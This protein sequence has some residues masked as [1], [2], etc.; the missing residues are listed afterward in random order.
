MMP[1]KPGYPLEKACMDMIGPLPLTPRNNRYILTMIDSYSKW[2]EAIPSTSQSAVVTVRLIVNHWIAQHGAPTVLHS[3]LGSNFC[4][5]VVR[6]IMKIF[7]IA[8]PNTTAFHSQCNG[9]VERFNRTLVDLIATGV[10]HA[11][12][13]WDL[14][15]GLVL[16]SHRTTIATHGYT[17]YFIL[18]GFDMRLPVDLQYVLP[19]PYPEGSV[20]DVARAY[21]AGINSAINTLAIISTLRIARNKTCTVAALAGSVTSQVIVSAYLRLY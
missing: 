8:Q 14:N 7:V 10:R 9:A 15:L 17:A 3:D 16:M 2:A 19:Q 5:R 18:H 6:D 1:I 13:N 21:H 11:A 12:D 4:S 20:H